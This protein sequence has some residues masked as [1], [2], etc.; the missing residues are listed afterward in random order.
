[1]NTKKIL[2]ALTLCL[3]AASNAM[4]MNLTGTGPSDSLNPKYRREAPLR[5]V[6][7]KPLQFYTDG[8]Y[9]TFK[10]NNKGDKQIKFRIPHSWRLDFVAHEGWSGREIYTDDPN[11]KLWEFQEREGSDVVTNA[12]AL[13]GERDGHFYS[14]ITTEHLNAYGLEGSRHLRTRVEN[15]NLILEIYHRESPYPGAAHAQD[16]MIVDQ[17]LVAAWDDDAQ[18]FSLS[19]I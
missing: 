2:A 7:G 16:L 10:P 18:W 17:T 3:A 19:S 13:V 12:Y 15:G 8:F 5:T 4:A 14:Y 1:M 9:H 11:F 6:E